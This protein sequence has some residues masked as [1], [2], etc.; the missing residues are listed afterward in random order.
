MAETPEQSFKPVDPKVLELV[1]KVVEKIKAGSFRERHPELGKLINCQ[2]CGQRHWASKVCHQRFAVQFIEED[3]ETGERTNVYAT[4]VPHHAK[5]PTV[6]QVIGAAIFK[7]K[8]RKPHVSAKKLRFI[9]KVRKL[10]TGVAVDLE[11]EDFKSMLNQA[12]HMAAREI[13]REDEAKAIRLRLQ[14]DLSRR[15][16]RGL[17]TPG[18]QI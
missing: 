18:T 9:E 17:A 11:S 8:R 16:N 1:N 10:M 6:N 5:H 13:S 2:V 15:I 4:A 3:V 7:G 14:Q 12:R